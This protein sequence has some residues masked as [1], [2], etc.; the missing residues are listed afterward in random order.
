MNKLFYK[1][2]VY[3][4]SD[5]IVINEQIKEGSEESTHVYIRIQK[6]CDFKDVK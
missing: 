2:Y 3:L 5:R 4:V 6:S 1:Y